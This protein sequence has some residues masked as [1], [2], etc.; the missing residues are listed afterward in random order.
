MGAMKHVKVIGISVLIFAV[1]MSTLWAQSTVL[2]QVPKGST[3]HSIAQKL[4]QEGLIKR[5]WQFKLYLKTHGLQNKLHAGSFELKTASSIK[6]IVTTLTE[7]NGAASLVKLTIPEGYTLTEIAEALGKKNIIHNPKRFVQ[8]V[9]TRG[10]KDLEHEFAFLSKI[11]TSNLEGYLFPETYTFARGVRYKTVLKTFLSQFQ[12]QIMPIW[13]QA[14]HKMGLHRMLTLASIVEKE[15]Y[16]HNEMS[17]ISGV[18]HNRLRKR[19]VLASCPTVGYAMGQPRKKFL[20]YAD[21]KYKSVYNTYTRQ[22]LPP[23]PIASPGVAAFKAA[24]QP[25]KT[26]YLYFVSNGDGTHQ[27]SRQLKEH[28]RKQQ[29]IL[30]R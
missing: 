4:K 14:P 17:I 12:N 16:K 20:T 2:F 28:L 30:N 15:A 22:G 26:P 11:P 10:R 8:Y 25:Q 3:G 18:F 6:E 27:F 24:M 21:L 9:Q 1:S 5:E 7:K 23:T 13:T 19:M 29:V